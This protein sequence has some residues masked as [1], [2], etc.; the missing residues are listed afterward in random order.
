ME[1]KMKTTTLTN[2]QN[3]SAVLQR[4]QQEQSCAANTIHMTANENVM[5]KTAEHFMASNL[6]YRYHFGTYDEQPNLQEE[7]FYIFKQSLALRCLP[8][9]FALEEQ[10][11]FCANKMFSANYCD[12]KPLS[13]MHAV[14][15]ILSTATKPGDCVYVFTKGSV[16]H[17][18]TIS[19]LNNIG[20]KIF[21]IPWCAKDVTID[22]EQL[23]N[24][25]KLNK[26]DAILF[27]FG[28]PFYPLPIKQVR[29]IVGDEVLMIYDGSHLLGLIAGG[30][31]QNP[32]VEG[33]DVLIGNTHKTFPGPQKAMLMFKDEKFG[34][35][36]S[37]QMFKSAL[38]T[39]HT[40]HT[41]ALYISI[42]EMME[43]GHNYAAQI[44]ENN[45]ALAKALISTGFKI[46]GRDNELPATH[47]IA[48]IGG[49]PKDHHHACAE[50]QKS[51]ISTNSRIV[52]GFNAVRLGVQ[53]VTYRGMKAKDMLQLADF[54][55]Q[56]ILDGKK[57]ITAE[58]QNF[59][60]KFNQRPYS[61]DDFLAEI[62]ARE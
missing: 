47:M 26:P 62:I 11:R 48:I 34:R 4:I 14:F 17:H 29:Q 53:E 45:H 12:F 37:D 21:F 43:H 40:H 39:Q 24:Q 3:V 61:F 19:I 30:Q 18:A 56:I 50:L 51:N 15:C 10:A 32:L 13:G 58:V 25:V 31:F 35:N 49:F 7:R 2:M 8:S 54:F 1:Q 9:V 55:K 60:K 23:A 27:D 28:V 20:R 59:N 44:V 22:L 16:E 46:F 6:S 5:S 57:Q 33:C 42:L 36:I 41:I 38:S 52:C